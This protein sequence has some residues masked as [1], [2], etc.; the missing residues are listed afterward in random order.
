MILYQGPDASGTY[1]TENDDG[2][3]GMDSRI[4]RRLTAGTHTVEASTYY[5]ARTGEFT[6]TV[7]VS[8]V[9]AAPGAPT[10]G[11]ATVSALDGSLVLSWSAPTDGTADTY[12]ELSVAA[13]S[14]T[15]TGLT[16]H[17]HTIPGA[18]LSDLSGPQTALVKACNGP[19][20]CG[21]DL[22]IGFLPPAPAP[23]NHSAAAAGATSITISWDAVSN[24]TGYEHD[25][26]TSTP[27][28]GWID[29]VG[30]TSASSTSRTVAG[31]ACGTSYEFR[32]RSAGNG[33]PYFNQWGP[34]SGSATASTDACVDVPSPPTSFAATAG[35]GEI[36]V[37]WGRPPPT[38]AR[39]L[40]DT[41]Y[42]TSTTRLRPRCIPRG[43]R[44]RP[45]HTRSPV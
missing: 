37:T 10:N 16:G 8:A 21:P 45:G 23:A 41:G 27:Q 28:G 30:S 33:N 44:C 17:S 11:N 18:L 3:P 34:W 20:A 2:G 25:Y 7:G 39:R 38:A 42:V 29:V 24:I 1:L 36:D 19:N 43:W 6:L 12:Y 4:T 35:N 31:L 15:R 40:S 5:T 32:T 22:S 14:Y 13:A 26:R 9:S